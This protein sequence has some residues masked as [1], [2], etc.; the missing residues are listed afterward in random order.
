M[1]LAR[2][3]PVPVRVQRGKRQACPTSREK[4]TKIERPRP[5]VT[6]RANFCKC[7]DDS[8]RPHWL[9]WSPVT[10]SEPAFHRPKYFGILEFE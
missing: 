8:S 5:G 9:T 4:S 10:D 3:P 7:A 2:Y 6:W 1:A